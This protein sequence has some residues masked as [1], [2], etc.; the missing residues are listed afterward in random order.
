MPTNKLLVIVF[1][2][3]IAVSAVVAGIMF[4][5]DPPAPNPV[6][7]PV[8]VT[9]PPSP[10]LTVVAAPEQTEIG[11]PPGFE[12][13]EVVVV[14]MPETPNLAEGK[15]LDSGA[16]TDVYVAPNALD[17]DPLTY[18]ESAGYPA[19]FTV[20]L[21]DTYAVKTVGI[22][23]NPA[24]IW[25]ARTQTFE[26]LGSSDGTTFETIVPE[27][28]YQFDPDTGNAI[29]V[30]FDAAEVQFVRLVFSANTGSVGAQAGEIMMFE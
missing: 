28:T 14:E 11:V 10:N 25:A 30:D 18:W 29:R 24:P 2:A 16:V 17:G 3:V 21:A 8:L 23:L 27:E 6:E 4:F 19:E 22:Q 13:P 5:Q 1:C 7:V 9:V 26:I 15:E 12:V 20:D